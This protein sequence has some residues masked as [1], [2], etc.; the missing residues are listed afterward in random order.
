MSQD[1]DEYDS[2]QEHRPLSQ[3]A[4]KPRSVSASVESRRQSRAAPFSATSP[5]PALRPTSHRAQSP[6][7][8][9][10]DEATI[11]PVRR[12][13]SAIPRSGGGPSLQA[14]TSP[15]DD[16][17]SKKVHVQSLAR[18]KRPEALA[19]D[20]VNLKQELSRA[21]DE[22]KLALTEKRRL[23]AELVKAKQSLLKSEELMNNK[24]RVMGS[25]MGISQ[26]YRSP[27]TTHL[28]GNL[29]EQNK[30]LRWVNML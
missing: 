15:G 2:R 1:N 5:R 25:T 29:K 23:E 6:L 11:L 16:G 9:R 4:P 17:G 8:A 10:N 21:K 3:S 28:V 12:V 22:A 26:L 18:N 14:W 27:D 13:Y 30:D 20:V 7:A 19:E 24:E